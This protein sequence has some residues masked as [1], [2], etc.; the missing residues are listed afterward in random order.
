[1]LSSC[2]RSGNQYEPAYAD[3]A[4]QPEGY[5]F[6]VHPLHNPALLQKTYGPL[7]DYLNANTGAKFKLVSSRDY[8]SFG[9]R[10]SSGEFDFALPNPYDTVLASAHGYRIFGKVGGD[11]NFRGIIITRRDSG[12]RTLQDL[13]GKAISYPA[14]TAVAGTMMPQYYLQQHGVPV[15]P[16]TVVYVGSMESSIESVL[17]RS[18]VAGALWPDPWQKYIRSHPE[19][20]RQLRV[21]WITPPLVNNGLVVRNDVPPEV[22][23]R[24]LVA[25]R[26][27]SKSPEGRHLLLQLAITEFEPANNATYDPVRR[28]VRRFS[29]TV[30]HVPMARQS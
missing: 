6:A 25:L 5:S 13:R 11:E 22:A 7:I 12:V 23:E 10:L 29:A 3:R 21:R 20:A 17:T 24:V 4:S 19:E 8:S 14:P 27:L 18:T 26:R 2:G 16:T 15:D 9:D 30:R 1:M 28:F